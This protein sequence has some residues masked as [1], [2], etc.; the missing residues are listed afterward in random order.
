MSKQEK[1]CELQGV[2]NDCLSLCNPNISPDVN[3]D[4]RKK[5]MATYS[6]VIFE[7]MNGAG[8]LTHV[9]LFMPEEI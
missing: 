2:P 7:C 5:C 8:K 3:S 9:G 1:C 4:E 6:A